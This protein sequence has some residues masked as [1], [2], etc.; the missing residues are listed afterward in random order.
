MG[1]VAGAEVRQ[2]AVGPVAAGNRNDTEPFSIS[3]SLGS[4]NLL[5]FR[6]LFLFS[7]LSHIS[8]L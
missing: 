1:V 4:N 2:G 5:P 7:Q 6:G 8:A 3:P